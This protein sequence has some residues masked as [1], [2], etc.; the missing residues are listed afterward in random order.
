MCIIYYWFK[1]EKIIYLG[2]W[3]NNYTV[4]QENSEKIQEVAELPDHAKDSSESTA[5]TCQEELSERMPSL[6]DSI[7]TDEQYCWTNEQLLYTCLPHGKERSCSLAL[8]EPCP[9]QNHA[10]TASWTKIIFLRIVKFYRFKTS[11]HIL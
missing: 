6:S 4:I 3:R 9:S 2:K 7:S 5:S 8:S 1:G 10:L 11:S